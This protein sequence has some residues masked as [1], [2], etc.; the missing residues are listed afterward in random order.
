MTTSE[1]NCIF[2]QI[3]DGTI[4]SKKISETT[5]TISFVS[6]YVSRE[7]ARAITLHTLQLDIFP[8]SYGHTLVVPKH[9]S[10][11]LHELSA[12]A[13][14]DLGSELVR[15]SRAIV[16]ATGCSDYNV[17][18]NN[19]QIAHQVVPHVHFH[20]IPVSSC[21]FSP[22]VLCSSITRRSRMKL[23]AYQLNGEQWKLRAFSFICC[24]CRPS[25]KAD[26]AVLAELHAKVTSV[27]Q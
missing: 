7:I 23:K 26:D 17:L 27:L 2:C 12:D 5:T 9:H 1:N 8:T 22:L 6:D 19:G 14:K 11:K 18:Q 10:A 4:P 13:V 3:V 20:I 15:V 16:Q 25:K 21:S 24:S